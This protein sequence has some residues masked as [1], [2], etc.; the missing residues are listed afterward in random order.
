MS[1]LPVAHAIGDKRPREEDQDE[2]GNAVPPGLRA[3]SNQGMGSRQQP[4]GMQQQQWQ[5]GGGNP[6]SQN[7][8]SLDSLYIA[9]LNWVNTFL[10]T[11]SSGFMS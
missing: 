10:Y 4:G 7:M 2:A 5:G 11:R 1:N 6:M 8:S 3:S 9:D